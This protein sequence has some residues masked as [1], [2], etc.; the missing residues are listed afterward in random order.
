MAYSSNLNQLH[1]W[2]PYFLTQTAIEPTPRLAL[3]FWC[4]VHRRI[5]E[6]GTEIGNRFLLLDYDH[7]CRRPDRGLSEIVEFLG[8][9]VGRSKMSVL[10]EAVRPPASV[11]R[12]RDHDISELDP[13]DVAFVEEMGF[14]TS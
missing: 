10:L 11:G 14:P 3:K 4:A 7:L 2:G 12:F 1:M 13:E 5:L 6:L 9:T 8:T